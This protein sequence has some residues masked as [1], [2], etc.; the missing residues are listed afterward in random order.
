MPF[1]KVGAQEMYSTPQWPAHNR[2]NTSSV[3]SIVIII[4]YF[5]DEANIFYI[6]KYIDLILQTKLGWFSLAGLAEQFI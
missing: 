5:T 3:V 1:V 4:M 2:M 6:I